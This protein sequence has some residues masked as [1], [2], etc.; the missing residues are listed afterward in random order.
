MSLN[1][2]HKVIFFDNCLYEKCNFHCK[3]CRNNSIPDK[4]TKESFDQIK[5]SIEITEKYV[6]PAILKISGYGEITLIQNFLKL[7]PH[8][9]PFQLITNGF[10]L[11]QKMI[12]IIARH[13]SFFICLSLDGHTF[14]MNSCRVEN[15][16]IHQRII[17]NL[18]LI[19]DRGIPIE[20]NSV[21][22][23]YNTA[24]Y[25]KFLDYLMQLRKKTEI[26]CYPFPVRPFGNRKNKDLKPY[27]QNIEL[28]EERVIKHF[29]KYEALLPPKKYL[30]R[31]MHF[32]V[33]G[34]K[35]WPCYTG[36]LNLG[37]V[38]SGD[39]VDCP[40]GALNYLGN[41]F[42]DP[43]QAFENRF[44]NINKLISTP[45]KPISP[46]CANCFNHYE[47][48]NLF[49]D[50]EISMKELQVIKLF[51]EKKVEKQLTTIKRELK[52]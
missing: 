22:T 34:Q 11:S 42:A 49:I 37:I 32:L 9:V 13:K 47:V 46:N 14:T 40:C 45:E 6:E 33:T 26:T 52:K 24:G 43:N 15:I 28:F 41:I 5:K 12:E 1:K 50:N 2:K 48:I 51:R 31:L 3:Y 23:K 19:A 4:N 7:I 39:L 35:N 30:E 44:N 27:K 8:D 17:E 25:Y 36:V 20:I 18:N 38:P 29:E 21:L 16:R 10:L